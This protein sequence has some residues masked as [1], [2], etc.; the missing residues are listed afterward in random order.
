MVGDKTLLV[1]GS[2]LHSTAMHGDMPSSAD[3]DWY[4]YCGM[5]E[6]V[7]VVVGTSI[8]TA[9]EQSNMS[10][11]HQIT[12]AMCLG[13]DNIPAEIG[14]IG[15]ISFLESEAQFQCPS[16]RDVQQFRRSITSLG[17][18]HRLDKLLSY[19]KLHL[20]YNLRE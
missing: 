7:L 16:R 4:E 2:P 1:E 18:C 19:C 12:T 14:D 20:R 8:D 17:H 13:A 9:A 10:A 11:T 5:P 3:S 6:N 15:T